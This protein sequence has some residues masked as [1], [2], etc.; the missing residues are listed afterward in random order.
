MYLCLIC[1][2][3]LTAKLVSFRKTAA[4]S[5]ELMSV[6]CSHA[7]ASSNCSAA[8]AAAACTDF[9]AADAVEPCV[10]EAEPSDEDAKDAHGSSD[11][12]DVEQDENADAVRDVLRRVV[13]RV[14]CDG[15]GGGEGKL[16][17]LQLTEKYCTI[18]GRRK[19]Q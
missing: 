14:A 5:N 4:R 9:E 11:H 16:L 3:R 6:E 13:D 1:I 15:D 7:P 10:S 8:V 18:F 17:L 2:I 12:D 19:L